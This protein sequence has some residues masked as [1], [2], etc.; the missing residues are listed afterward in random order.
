MQD[1]AE[2]ERYELVENTKFNVVYFGRWES[3]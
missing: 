2:E 3:T 1:I